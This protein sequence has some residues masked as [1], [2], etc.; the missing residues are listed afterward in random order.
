MKKSAAL[1]ILAILF[2]LVLTGCGEQ[3]S[4]EQAELEAVV[5]RC[6]KGTCHPDPTYMAIARQ[7]FFENNYAMWTAYS[8]LANLMGTYDYYVTIDIDGSNYTVVRRTRYEVGQ[9]ITVTMV[10]AYD[11]SSKLVNTQYK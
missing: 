6:D 9:Y 11:T 8:N 10:N 5:A 7:Y 1:V 3:Y 4:Y 2:A